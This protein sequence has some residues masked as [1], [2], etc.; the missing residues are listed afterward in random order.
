MISINNSDS[1]FS[2]FETPFD[3]HLYILVI[4]SI[5]MSH[6]YCRVISSFESI[7]ESTVMNVNVTEEPVIIEGDDAALILQRVC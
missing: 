6:R 5:R 2:N 4:G 1:E 3:T 7:L